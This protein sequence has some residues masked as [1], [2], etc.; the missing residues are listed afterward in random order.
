MELL[1]VG[2]LEAFFDYG[3]YAIGW[4]LLIIAPLEILVFGVMKAFR[5]LKP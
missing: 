4:G 5:L 1:D 3:T 2:L